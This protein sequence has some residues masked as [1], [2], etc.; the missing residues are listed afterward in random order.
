MVR[1]CKRISGDTHLEVPNERWTHRVDPA[2]RQR[3]PRTVRL[4]SGGDATV[5]E[6][7][8]PKQNTSDLYGGKGRDVWYPAGQTYDSM[9][10]TGSPQQR[11]KE[12]EM[13]GIDAEVMFPGV[14]CGPTL[15]L[16]A[17]DPGLQKALVRGW[18]DWFAEEY[19]DPVKERIFGIGTLTGTGV[20]DCIAEMEHCKNLGFVGV[21]L[22]TFPNGGGR[23]KPEDDR[24]W[25][26]ALD[27]Q[28]PVTIHFALART[29]M[30]DRKLLDYPVEVPGLRTDLADQ[31]TRFARAAGTNAVQLV[32]AGVFDRFPDLRIFCAETQIG[33]IPHFLEMA[34]TRYERHIPW[35]ERLNGFTPLKARPSELINEYFYWGFQRDWA[36]VDLRHHLNVE[37]LIWANDFPHQE[38]DWPESCK[39]LQHNFAGVPEDEVRKMTL[40]NAIDFFHLPCVADSSGT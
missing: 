4:E 31:M 17:K 25:A 26:A 27:L 2:Y 7:L 39:V 20:D 15:W 18:N 16:Q 29:G 36:G 32:L 13:D 35:S 22:L 12:Q 30:P 1:K 40:Q 10:G 24:F 23:P 21:Q 28:M 33:W 37:R 9:G 34:D 38:S 14:A 3:A 8:P 6:D 5:F 19:I 11:V